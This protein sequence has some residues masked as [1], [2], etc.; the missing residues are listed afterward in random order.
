MFYE[1]YENVSF[2]FLTRTVIVCL[3]FQNIVRDRTDVH[4]RPARTGHSTGT[5]RSTDRPKADRRVCGR[6]R[7]T[8]DDVP[9]TPW[10]DQRFT[11]LRR[12][13]STSRV[14]LFLNVLLVIF[15]YI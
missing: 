13:S 14:I 12:R 8:T 4:S 7:I 9:G 11:R 5:A 15:I 3:R 6:G 10:R 1:R 2:F